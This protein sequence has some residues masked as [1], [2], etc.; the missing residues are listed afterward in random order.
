MTLPTL[1]DLQDYYCTNRTV[2]GKD[3]R[4]ENPY[5]E[6][7]ATRRYNYAPSSDRS[8]CRIVFLKDVLSNPHN[9]TLCRHGRFIWCK[10]L[11][12]EGR[13][14]EG[15]REMSFCVDK[16]HKRFTVSERNMLCIPS[17]TCV[18]NSRFVRTKEK[19]FLAFSSVFSYDNALA[20]MARNSEQEPKQFAGLVRGD[21]P[22]KPG[23]LVCPRLGYF[24][25]TIGDSKKSFEF[26]LGDEHPYGIILGR[27]LG[28][29]YTGREFYRV[30]FGTTTYE[31]IHP[32][33]MEIINEV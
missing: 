28:G 21:T 7:P 33:Q 22:F 2:L 17:K 24:Y 30:K 32:V 20:L 18:N 6:H 31:K 10:D 9:K 26:Q 11:K 12:Y 13:N 29:D 4:E 23:T 1:K 15:Y 8:A 19:T 27:S 16:G 3:G 5:F 14:K 25:P